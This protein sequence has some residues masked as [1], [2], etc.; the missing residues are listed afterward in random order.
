MPKD[1]TQ[2]QNIPLDCHRPLMEASH[3]PRRIRKSARNVSVGSA[4]SL[5]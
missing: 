5:L 3:P 4:V 2:T 1:W